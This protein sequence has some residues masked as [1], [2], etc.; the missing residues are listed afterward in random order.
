MFSIVKTTVRRFLDREYNR[1][2]LQRRAHRR[3]LRRIDELTSD[4]DYTVNLFE[5]PIT[6][7]DPKIFLAT[8]NE[9]F[10]SKVYYFKTDR[11]DPVVIDC[12]AN[13]GLAV[14]YFKQLYPSS[15]II[16]FEPDPTIFNVLSDNIAA[17]NLSDVILHNACV[18]TQDGQLPFIPDGKE[19]GR[20]AG[21]GAD[22][23]GT[24]FVE[25][26]D[27]RRFLSGRVDFLKIDIEGAE[28][29]IIPHCRDL[30]RNVD[31]IVLEYH[32]IIHEEQRFGSIVTSLEEA[33]FRLYIS[34]L[35]RAPLF[36]R[37]IHGNIDMFLNI[38]GYREEQS[39][40][41][42]QK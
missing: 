30:L 32:S 20:I 12:G 38:F 1:T 36:Y 39:G 6:I 17:L 3:E 16:A 40:S 5:K 19:G 23:T 26:I 9:I 4:Q 35:S 25:S 8:Y 14:I 37:T 28:R 34:S 11:M 24:T 33:G 27:F 29:Y 15:K 41:P 22:R 31:N 7:F 18:W 21:N 42:I 2:Y 13:I 10:A